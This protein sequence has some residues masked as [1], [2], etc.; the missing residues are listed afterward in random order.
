MAVGRLAIPGRLMPVGGRAEGQRALADTSG[1]G[2]RECRRRARRSDRS[3]EKHAIRT[4]YYR[5]RSAVRWYEGDGCPS[6]RFAA[7]GSLI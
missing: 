5:N 2:C 4:R 3:K 1:I 6:D 7:R